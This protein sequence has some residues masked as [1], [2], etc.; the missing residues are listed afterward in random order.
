MV[1]LFAWTGII[2]VML[3]LIPVVAIAPILLYIGMLIGA[4]AFQETPRSHAPAIVLSLAP[5]IAAWGKVQIDNAL[6][7]AGTNAASVGMDKLAQVGVLYEGLTVLGGG[8]ILAGLVL[9]AIG[10][11]VIERQFSKAAGFAVAGAVLSFFGFMHGEAIGFGASKMVAVSYLMVSGVL[12]ACAKWST[13]LQ[14][15]PTIKEH[16]PEPVAAE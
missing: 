14:G 9:G 1:I 5:H 16:D 4:Q 10:V 13:A 2:P 12:L 7:A 11:F 3:A 6:G 8:A 15:E